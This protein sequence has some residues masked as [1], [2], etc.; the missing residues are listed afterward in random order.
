M[1]DVDGVHKPPPTQAID[2]RRRDAATKLAAVGKALKTMGRSGAQINR[3]DIARLAGVSRSFT[4]K[5]MTRTR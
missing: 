3:I 1:S 2:A 4:T 5:T